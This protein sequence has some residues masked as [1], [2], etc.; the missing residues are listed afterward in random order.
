MSSDDE[1]KD[2]PDSSSEGEPVVVTK[3]LRRGGVSAEAMM[4]GSE[5]WQ[6]PVHEKSPEER[7]QLSEIF[8]NSQDGKLHM[9]FGSVKPAIFEK[10]L[11]AM[12]AK[13]IATDQTVMSQGDVGD[14]FYIV[15][16]GSF[17]I[18]VQKGDAAPVKVFTAGR[19]FAFGELALLY[20]APRSAT[21]KAACDSEVWCLD[22]TAFRNLVVRSAE[23]QFQQYLS[24]LGKVEVF[25]TLSEHEK[26]TLTEVL[27]EESFANDEAIIE[28]GDQDDKFFMILSGQAVACIKGEQGEVEV[29]QYKEGDYFG[30]IALL[31]GEPRKASVY[32]VGPTDC[33]YITRQTF[34]RVLG[35]LHDILKRN[36]ERYAKYQDAINAPQMQV[37][38]EDQD[39]DGPKIA[40]KRSVRNRVSITDSV[41]EHKVLEASAAVGESAPNGGSGEAMTL[42]DKIELDFKRPQLV[43]P[44]EA[45]SVPSASM[46]IFGGVVPRQKFAMDK[47]VHVR[48]AAS[49]QEVGEDRCF[50]W[51]GITKVKGLTD[52]SVVCQKGQKAASDPTPNQDNF[53]VNIDGAV[54]T[55]GVFDGHG[56][57]GHL[58]SLRLVQSMPYHI[59]K[60]QHYG[61]DWELTLKDAFLETQRELEEFCKKENVNIEASGAAGSVLVLQEQTVHI[62]FI[63][64]ARVVLGS[65]NRRDS[66]MIFTSK[67]HKPDIPEEKARLEAAGSEVREL[68]PGNSRI[69]RTGTNFPGLTMSR[70]FGDTACEGV[71]REPEYHKFLM[72]PA[73][74]WYAIIASDGIWEFFEGEEVCN[75]SAKKLRLKGPRETNNFLVS[76]SR[77]RW[78]HVCGDYCDD[79][80][81]ILV[82]WNSADAPKNADCNHQLTVSVKEGMS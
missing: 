10:I 65:W 43:S 19:G 74:Q 56:P 54:T 70:A 72:Q 59:S 58:I 12:F 73:D 27:L 2:A 62:A 35:P 79:I 22:R 6:P 13:V 1:A 4:R 17:D 63:G 76:A 25:Q 68:E 61:T 77:K 23:Q 75:I 57:F 53:F 7:K 28:Q 31:T 64:D 71:L 3:S 69:Y 26:A 42:A 78:A 49:S 37:P 40:K 50:T 46:M 32:A 80:T 34:Q 21:I 15:K 55:Y 36:I 11:D 67:D 66:R 16:T 33:I 47:F 29:M 38:G 44:C 60:S 5:D 45:L 52:I 41:K 51:Q 48:S 82:Q 20:N 30:E 8:Q 24:F 81:S 18:L 39:D 14:Y 9:L